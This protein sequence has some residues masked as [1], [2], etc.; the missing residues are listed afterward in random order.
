MKVFNFHG[1][2]SNNFLK[3][4]LGNKYISCLIVHWQQTI[5]IELL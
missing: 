1:T 5:Q 2:E 3:I 4:K